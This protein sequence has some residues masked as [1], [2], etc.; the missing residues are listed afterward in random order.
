MTVDCDPR[1]PRSVRGSPLGYRGV[2]E[3]LDD[4][5]PNL[6]HAQVQKDMAARKAA[7]R[8]RIAGDKS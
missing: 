4:P 8:K 6:S 3:S 5:R 2:Y 1:L 7:L